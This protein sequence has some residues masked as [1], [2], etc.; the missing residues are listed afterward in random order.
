MQTPK[1]S[2]VQIVTDFIALWEE[3]D[4]FPQAIDTYFTPDTVWENHG[5]ITTRGPEEAIGFYDQFG[6]ATGMAGM[7]IDV[8]AI[9]ETGN[10][11]TVSKVLTERVDYILD[12]GG[13]TVMTVPVMGI[14]EV[15]M[16]QAGGGRITAW[17]DYFDTIANSP[18]AD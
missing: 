2:G 18:P 15:A 3:P 12:A 16:D 11:D 5:L 10:P 1:K 14:F 9:A 7:R 17:R 13:E 6:A 8:L 4:G